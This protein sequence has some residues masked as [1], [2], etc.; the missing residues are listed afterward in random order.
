ML[1]HVHRPKSTSAAQPTVAPPTAPCTSWPCR[2]GHAHR[3]CGRRDSSRKVRRRADHRP[4]RP[5]PRPGGTR[6]RWPSRRRPESGSCPRA[7]RT[8][9]AGGPARRSTRSSLAPV[10]R[11]GRRRG[12]SVQPEPEPDDEVAQGGLPWP[13][14]PALPFG[15]DRQASQ[16]RAVQNR[17]HGSTVDHQGLVPRDDQVEVVGAGEKRVEPRRVELQTTRPRPSFDPA[18]ARGAAR[19]R[20]CAARRRC[21][22]SS[23]VGRRRTPRPTHPPKTTVAFE[24]RF[25]GLDVATF[26]AELAQRTHAASW[27]VLDL[28]PLCRALHNRVRTSSDA[29]PVASPGG[30]GGTLSPQP[31][32]GLRGA[33][34][35]ARSLRNEVLPG[36]PCLAYDQPKTPHAKRSKAPRTQGPACDAPR[37]RRVGKARV[38]AAAESRQPPHDPPAISSGMPRSGSRH[39]S[40]SSFRSRQRCLRDPCS[41]RTTTWSCTSRHSRDR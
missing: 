3:R 13:P 8:P 28:P 11:V 14:Q 15:A 29:H 2:R 39:T 33:G 32:P 40:R 5:R 23:P 21:T 22:R 1:T 24:R 36:H 9:A 30:V 10:V 34:R 6:S 38:E 20:R 17:R 19:T 25:E 26:A 12:H 16:E 31:A 4:C 35:A 41:G 18:G 27:A 37:M 7:A